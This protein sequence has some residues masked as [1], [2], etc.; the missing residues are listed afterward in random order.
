[1]NRKHRKKQPRDIWSPD[2]F[3]MKMGAIYDA[4]QELERGSTIHVVGSS[5]VFDDTRFRFIL[6]GEYH[7]NRYTC[8]IDGN[9]VKDSITDIWNNLTHTQWQQCFGV[10]FP[11][12]DK[13]DKP[14][15]KI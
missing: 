1:M 8:T 9:P 14:D 10:V 6:Y 3:V 13:F 7:D 2:T 11:E 15:E 12:F 4:I 5:L